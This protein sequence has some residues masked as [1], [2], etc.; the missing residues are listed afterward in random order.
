MW[1]RLPHFS[2]HPNK[3]L[4]ISVGNIQTDELDFRN[5]LQNAF[6]LIEIGRSCTGGH[7]WKTIGI[8][9]S[10]SLPLLNR[11]VLVDGGKQSVL[12]G[13]QIKKILHNF[14]LRL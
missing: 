1:I 3:M 4:A 2:H 5:S 13:F 7:I 8:G 9:S 11:I 6:Q 14:L 10:E 12:K